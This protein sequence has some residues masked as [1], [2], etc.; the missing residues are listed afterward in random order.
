MNW[1][2]VDAIRAIQPDVL[3]VVKAQ[4]SLV[5]LF[6]Y[7]HTLR[8]IAVASTVTSSWY[9]D[10]GPVPP[11]SFLTCRILWR[12]ADA[13]D[14]LYPGFISA[15]AE[16]MRLAHKVAVSPCSFSDPTRFVPSE[17]KGRT[18]VFAGRLIEEKNPLMFAEALARLD[19]AYSE[20]DAVI[21][22]AGPLEGE[23]RSV[24]ARRRLLGKVRVGPNPNMETVLGESLVFVSI[25]RRENYP[26]QALLEGMLAENAVVATDVGETRRLVIDGRTGLLIK[27]NADALAAALEMLLRR[28]DDARAM[29]AEGRQLVLREHTIERFATYLYALWERAWTNTHARR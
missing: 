12:R 14:S 10:G 2:V 11:S 27:P 15:H 13:I 3:H 25:Q 7:L 24:L 5:P 17:R 16:R 21:A 19:A 1:Q 28:P 29:G 6:A 18:I 23:L 22:G 20:W 26:S 9:A 8:S 4:R